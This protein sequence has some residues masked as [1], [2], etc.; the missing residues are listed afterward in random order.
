MKDIQNAGY[1]DVIYPEELE[2][3]FDDISDDILDGSKEFTYD[4]GYTERCY[5]KD[6]Y[7][8]ESSYNYNASLATMSLCFAVSAFGAGQVNDYEN[9]SK[10]A[11]YMLNSII[12]VSDNT[13]ETNDWFKTKPTTDSIGVIAGNKSIKVGEENYTLIAVA[14]RGGGYEKEWASNFTI[15]SSGQHVGFNTAKNNV[16][17]F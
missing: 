6:S 17:A 1:Y 9:K 13:I 11:R 2:F 12:G 10:N 5:Y 4:N 3:A 15:G 16:I 8:N 14:I 7:F